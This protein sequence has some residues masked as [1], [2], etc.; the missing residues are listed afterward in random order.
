MCQALIKHPDVLSL[1]SQ[2]ARGLG[3]Q[4]GP[5]SPPRLQVRK[6]KHRRV[7][8]YTPR[9]T[10]PTS[11]GGVGCQSNRNGVWSELRVY[12]WLNCLPH[13]IYY[14]QP[15]PTRFYHDYCRWGGPGWEGCVT[16]RQSPSWRAGIGIQRSRI[17]ER[18]LCG[19]G[20][21]RGF[22]PLRSPVSAHLLRGSNQHWPVVENISSLG[23]T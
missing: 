21:F 2:H 9:S 5:A 7:G 4:V 18:V 12:R 16:F 10:H 22:P 6:P 23:R 1:V 8:T 19:L 14:L 3:V 17:A 15:P 11:A 13:L 20:S